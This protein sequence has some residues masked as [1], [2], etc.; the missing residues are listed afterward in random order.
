[1]DKYTEMQTEGKRV[2]ELTLEE[3]EDIGPEEPVAQ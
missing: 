1:M 2:R 3:V